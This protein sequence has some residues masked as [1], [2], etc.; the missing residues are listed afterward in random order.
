MNMGRRELW[1]ATACLDS[2]G[3][4]R[5]TS[6]ITSLLLGSRLPL[7]LRGRDFTAIIVDHRDIKGPAEGESQGNRALEPLALADLIGLLAHREST[8]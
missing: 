4:I 3:H 7:I 1:V 6:T 2:Q 5:E 8:K